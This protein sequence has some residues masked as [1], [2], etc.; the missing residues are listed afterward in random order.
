[1][2]KYFSRS[3]FQFRSISWIASWRNSRLKE[4]LHREV[5]IG[6][7]S[8]IFLKRQFSV[9]LLYRIT[10]VTDYGWSKLMPD[11]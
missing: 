5:N 1:M 7:H 6:F 10:K 2:M 8:N 3:E 9:Q 11:D 4:R